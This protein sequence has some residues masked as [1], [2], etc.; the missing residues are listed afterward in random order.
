MA[1]ALIIYLCARR[2]HSQ[3]ILMFFMLLERQQE[4]LI[5]LNLHTFY[6]P[7]LQ[8]FSTISPNGHSLLRSIIF[9]QRTLQCSSP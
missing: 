2:P 1:A 7:V 6:V 4:S 8:A 3:L 9:M 5:V